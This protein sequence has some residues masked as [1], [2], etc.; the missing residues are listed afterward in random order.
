LFT[1]YKHWGDS[2]FVIDH[3]YGLQRCTEGA[4]VK[5]VYWIK[6]I[7]TD[8]AETDYF[9]FFQGVKR[10]YPVTF[11]AASMKGIVAPK[12]LNVGALTV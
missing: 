9:S 2:C 5:S 1:D 7:A 4:A 8:K 12:F 10:A 6:K 3:W 11:R